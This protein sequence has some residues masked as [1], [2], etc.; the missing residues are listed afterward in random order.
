M[1][2]WLV[3]VFCNDILMMA[4]QCRNTLEFMY[5]VCYKVH[6]LDGLIIRTCTV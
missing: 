6:L 4:P 3:L 2:G 5:V 1:A